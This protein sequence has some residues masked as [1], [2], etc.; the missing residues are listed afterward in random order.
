MTGM[1]GLNRKRLH[2]TDPDK[3]DSDGDGHN[4]KDENVA[5][6]DPLDGTDWPGK[7]NTPPWILFKSKFQ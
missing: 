5:G 2:G 6:T 3:V 4:D 1:N 7:A